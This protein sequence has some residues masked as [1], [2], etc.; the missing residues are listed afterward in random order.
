MKRKTAI[1]LFIIFVI[2]IILL[3]IFIYS[4]YQFTKDQDKYDPQQTIS[5]ANWN[6]QIFG[7]KKANNSELMNL[8]AEKI[9]SYDIIFLQE[10]RDKDSN[11]FF[12]LCSM[13]PDYNCKISSRAGRSSSKEQYGI[14]YLKKFQLN[15]VDYNPDSLDRWERPPVRAD[16]YY[17]NYS[18]T[19]YNIHTK[20]DNVSIELSNLE[21]LIS[22][23][24]NQENLIVLGDL[25]ADCNY[26]NPYSSSLFNDWKW[27]IDNNADT[28]SQNSDCAYDRIIMNNDAYREFIKTGID[29][30]SID[31]KVSD[32]YLVYALI[33]DNDYQKD[34][35]FK[36]Y[37]SS[38]F[39]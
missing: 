4:Y 8:Y 37:L 2:I 23:E 3:A 14:V 16:I 17:H 32:H 27:V 20:P 38:V 34:K 6:L 5:I 30:E 33:R 29:K 39:S 35:T 7:D 36:A 13:L 18:F 10:I 21:S 28:T 12:A 22:S 1:I 11:S 25:N 9:S 24:T 26:F 15:I 31:I 19:A